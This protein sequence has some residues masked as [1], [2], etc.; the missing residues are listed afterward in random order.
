MFGYVW[1]V[2]IR[3]T[4]FQ[5]YDD[6]GAESSSSESMNHGGVDGDG[7]TDERN[8]QYLRAPYLRR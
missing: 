2:W 4:M 5:D 8:V 3:W 1:I 7:E 6:D